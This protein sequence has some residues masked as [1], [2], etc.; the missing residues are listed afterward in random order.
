MLQVIDDKIH[1]VKGDAE[2][3]PVNLSIGENTPYEMGESEYLVLTVRAIPDT[4]SPALFIAKS[5]P[6]SNRIIITKEMTAEMDPGYYSADIEIKNADISP[7]TVWPDNTLPY[8]KPDKSRN[9]KN[10]ILTPE[11]TS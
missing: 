3:L 7:N 10:Y 2:I 9:W 5:S 4:A 11:V 1:H 6:G 8:V